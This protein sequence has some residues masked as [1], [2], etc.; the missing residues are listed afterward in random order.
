M[1]LSNKAKQQILRQQMC[2][3]FPYFI[4]ITSDNVV[5]R[6]VNA[7]DDMVYDNNTYTA[8]YFS[9][10]PPEKTESRIGDGKITFSAIYNN[11]EWVKKIRN[12]TTRASIRIV[13]AIIY[14]AEGVANGIEPIYDTEFELCEASWDDE[15]ISLTMKFDTGMDIQIPSDKMDEIVCPGVV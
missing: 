14:T 10:T 8:C 1:S 9:I 11:R 12:T 3:M 6:Y 4:E 2:A 7:D 5:Y 13:A 15:S